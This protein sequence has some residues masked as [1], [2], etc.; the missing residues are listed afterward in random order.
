MPFV[1]ITDKDHHK[2][3]L[4]MTGEDGKMFKVMEIGYTRKA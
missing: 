1:T 4:F 2:Y 3:E